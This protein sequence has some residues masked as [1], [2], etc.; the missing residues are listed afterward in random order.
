MGPQ[1]PAGSVVGAVY[2]RV[3]QFNDWDKGNASVYCNAGDVAI[4]GGGLLDEANPKNMHTSAPIGAPLP[5]G[6]TVGYGSKA[7]FWVYAICA[8]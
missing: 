2:T 5:T 8:K 3:V 1:G 6:W 7:T 4:G